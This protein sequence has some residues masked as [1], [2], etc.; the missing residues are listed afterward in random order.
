MN[1]LQRIASQHFFPDCQELDP[2]QISFLASSNY[3]TSTF[4]VF[5]PN[6]N[7]PV[8]I[9]RISSTRQLVKK[10]F[11]ILRYIQNYGG[12]FL[13]QSVSKPIRLTQYG[14]KYVASQNY[15]SSNRLKPPSWFESKR[16]ITIEGHF[17]NIRTWLQSLWQIPLINLSEEDVRGIDIFDELDYC[18]TKCDRNSE[19]FFNKVLSTAES[20]RNMKLPLVINHND[21]SLDNIL[22]DLGKIKVIDWELSY[23]T[24]P[25]YDWFYFVAN[26]AH[27]LWA[28]RSM[29]TTLVVKSIKKAFF[30]C[31]WF[32]DIVKA[33]TKKIYADMNLD[34]ELIPLFYYLAIFDFLYRKYFPRLMDIHTCAPL[35]RLQNL[36]LT[37]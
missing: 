4:F 34:K 5:K 2:T 21:L 13:K 18:L 15:I 30:E 14:T 32:S 20:V 29:K 31:N 35:F 17:N 37:R 27:C 22:F 12:A 28:G 19:G 9:L 10:E 26:Y 36:Y 3:K 6:N 8:G 1:F 16:K 33:Q 11:T 23:I 7:I 24:W 25:V